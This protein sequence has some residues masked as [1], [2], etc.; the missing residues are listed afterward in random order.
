MEFLE[1]V[2][3][4]QEEPDWVHEHKRKAENSNKEK[5]KQE[6]FDIENEKILLEE[7]W[8]RIENVQRYDLDNWLEYGGSSRQYRW[9]GPRDVTNDNYWNSAQD[10]F[11]FTLHTYRHFG[12]SLD[13]GMCR[14]LRF[15]RNNMK[16]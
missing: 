14:L 5:K 15:M 10:K 4:V 1:E 2:D 6:V 12:Q 13:G 11:T 8:K 7:T 9:K 3:R 16:P